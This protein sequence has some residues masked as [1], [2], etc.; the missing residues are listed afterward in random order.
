MYYKLTQ[1]IGGEHFGRAEYSPMLFGYDKPEVNVCI[2]NSEKNA[3]S[4]VVIKTE[5]VRTPKKKIEDEFSKLKSGFYSNDENIKHL[6][7][8]LR[9]KLEQKSENG[10][11]YTLPYDI[12]PEYFRSYCSGIVN[13]LK[14]YSSRTYK[15]IR[16]VQG[17]EGSNHP[18]NNTELKWSFDE[19]EWFDFPSWLSCELSIKGGL[20]SSPKLITS[21]T[22]IVQSGGSEPLSHEL[23]REAYGI[24]SFYPRS[25]LLIAVSAAEAATKRC[26]IYFR[27]ET[28]WLIENTA[29]PDIIT[30]YRDYIHGT[31]IKDDKSQSIN[32]PNNTIL[33]PLRK[34]IH[35]RNKLAHG[36]TCSINEDELV[37]KLHVISNLLWVIDLHM[38][39]EWASKHID[40]EVK[41]EMGI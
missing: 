10:L 4:V 23:L 37:K 39:Y 34:I 31:L 9:S 16:W 18:F 14:S 1:E 38:G 30:L 5:F 26:I 41:K 15:T 17:R 25:A 11:G 36:G 40:S 24:I 27:N 2:R 21:V 13:E 12:L 22:K 33:N 8:D 35:M 6:V 28:Q 7:A 20:Y 29:S 32:L 19:V 3:G